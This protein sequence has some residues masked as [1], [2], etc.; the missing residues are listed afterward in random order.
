MATDRALERYIERIRKIP[1]LDRETEHGLAVRAQQGDEAAREALVRANLRYVVSVALQ[2]RAYGVRLADLLAE[3]NLG[4]VV[5]SHKFDPDRGTRFVTYAGYWIRAFVL[6]AVVKSTTM[7][8]GGTGPL[9]SKLF[10]RL[11]RERARLGTLL[12]DD[13]ERLQE[14]ARRFGVSP[15]RMREMLRRVDARDVSLD[16]KRFDDGEGTLLDLLPAE[17]PDPETAAM[18]AER[19]QVVSQALH[20]ALHTLDERER[21]IVERRLLDDEPWSLAALGRQLGVSRE[22]ARQLEARAKKKMRRHFERYEALL[23]QVPSR[24]AA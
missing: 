12:G 5:A 2:Y 18:E 11:R 6:D 20:E 13:A 23:E 7:V 16:Q 8:G 21:F 9:R 3:G 24:Q 10:F 17:G 15:E 22:R 4:L 19:R 1:V 14:M